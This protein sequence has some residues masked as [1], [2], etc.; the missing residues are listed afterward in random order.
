MTLYKKILLFAS[1]LAGFSAC[2]DGW[3][4][5]TSL[6]DPALN[7]NIMQEINTNPRISRFNELLVQTGF[8]E[9]LRSSKSFTVWAPTNEALQNLDQTIVN[10]PDRLKQFVS[11]HISYQQYFTHTTLPASFQ[12]KTLSGKNILWDKATATVDAAKIEEANKYAGNGVLHIV[13][14]PLTPRMNSWEFLNNTTLSPRQKAYMLSLDERVFVDSL[15][16]QTG[17]DPVTGKPVYDPATGFV[18]QNRFFQRAYNIANEDSVYTFIMLTD[19]AYNAEF[20]RFRKFFATST[21]DSTDALT[22]WAVTKDLAFR[23]VYTKETLPET[24]ISR[25]GV[26]V[27]IDRNAVVREERT[28]NGI[29]LVVNSLTVANEEK[30]KP[31]RVEGESIFDFRV[32]WLSHPDKVG[33]VSVQTRRSEVAG[34]NYRYLRATGHSIS[35]LWLRYVIPN[36]YSTKYKVYWSVINDFNFVTRNDIRALEPFNQRIVLGTLNATVFPYKAVAPSSVPVRQEL[37]EYSVARYGNLDAFLR[38]ALSTDNTINP[39]TLDY[40]ELV[41]VF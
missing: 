18:Q 32:L 25:S 30:I 19:E 16:V 39:L 34:E 3:E 20:G 6:N 17:V 1:I 33:N 36:V 4:E 5:H 40:L 14:A 31:I 37:G 35:G 22:N 9:V 23:G 11:N 29:V 24:L 27:H 15:A 13:G 26:Q 21:A 28:S 7:Q 38:S 12:I 8:D 10:S 2:Q 41:P